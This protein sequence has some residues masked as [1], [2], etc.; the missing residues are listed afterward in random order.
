MGID[1]DCAGPL[2]PVIGHFLRQVDRVDLLPHHHAPGG[3]LHGRGALLVW[4][5]LEEPRQRLLRC[6]LARAHDAGRMA[7]LQHPRR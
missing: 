7:K 4:L 5:R 2:R 3:L 6:L 1:D